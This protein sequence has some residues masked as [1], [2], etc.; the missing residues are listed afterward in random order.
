MNEPWLQHTM[1]N[2]EYSSGQSVAIAAR[3]TA[4]PWALRIQFA[5]GGGPGGQNVNKLNTKAELWLDPTG[6]RG[7]G[8][9]ARA[10][11]LAL[12]AAH[13]TAAGEIHLWSTTHR[14]Q[15]RNRQDVLRKLRELVLQALIEP[16]KRRPTRPTAASRQRRLDAKR[17]RS[18]LKAQ[19]RPEA[20]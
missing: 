13:L 1:A 10:R 2:M 12:A 3:V 6:L 17:R 15:E 16:K 9:R 14:T 7:I 4:E 18:R 5:R 20:E 11:L 19:R 8:P